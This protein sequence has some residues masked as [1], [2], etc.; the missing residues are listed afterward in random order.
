MALGY[1]LVVK[2]CREEKESEEEFGHGASCELRVARGSANG[3]P[4]STGSANGLRAST[5]SANGLS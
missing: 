3:L 2:K 4:A 1:G 5:S